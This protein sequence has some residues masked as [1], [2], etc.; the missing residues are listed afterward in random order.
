MKSEKE[1]IK[2]SMILIRL[3]MKKFCDIVEEDPSKAYLPPQRMRL[4]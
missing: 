1:T 2:S 4:K 3:K